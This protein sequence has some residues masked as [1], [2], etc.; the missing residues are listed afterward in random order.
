M[1]MDPATE[2]LFLGIAHALF[3][4]RLHVLRLTE[5]VRLGIRP[6]P[7]DQNMEV[8]DDLDKIVL[9]ALAPDRENRIPNATTFH[10]HL[11]DVLP[12]LHS[13]IRPDDIR[14][15]VER[16]TGDRPP[17]A[18]L[19]A[20]ERSAIASPG[21]RFDEITSPGSGPLPSTRSRTAS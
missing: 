18:S 7:H 2:E 13:G 10:S 16:L 15:M 4:N 17:L 1:A 11:L 9:W 6:D 3:V 5:I 19:T 12:K 8:P 14:Q 21:V 20:S